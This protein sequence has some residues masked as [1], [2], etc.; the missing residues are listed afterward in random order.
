MSPSTHIP[1]SRETRYQLVC[2]PEI[3]KSNDILYSDV[4]SLLRLDIFDD[5]VEAKILYD[6][7]RIKTVAAAI[8]DKVELGQPSSE[9]LAE[10][11]SELL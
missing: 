2:T 10:F 7:S 9:D 8:L 3:V 5:T 1:Q 11:V 4:Y 6:I